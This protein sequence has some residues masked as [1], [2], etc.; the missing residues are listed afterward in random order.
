MCII[1]PPHRYLLQAFSPGFHI[2]TCHLCDNGQVY[3][4]HLTGKVRVSAEGPKWH[5]QGVCLH[6]PHSRAHL[7]RTLNPRQHW[8]WQGW[9]TRAERALEAP[10]GQGPSL[11]INVS[12]WFWSSS[13]KHPHTMAGVSWDATPCLKL[14]RV[15]PISL[16]SGNTTVNFQAGNTRSPWSGISRP[17]Y[18]S[19][20]PFGVGGPPYFFSWIALRF[21]SDHSKTRL[22]GNWAKP[23]S[24]LWLPKVSYEHPQINT[25]HARLRICFSLSLDN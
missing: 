22:L 19:H 6:L 24:S 13:H 23:P 15:H 12:F 11:A 14:Y 5:N 8:F 7:L 1:W 3:Y 2:T 21:S 20:S 16:P 9:T 10:W 4:S 18:R 25:S 17:S